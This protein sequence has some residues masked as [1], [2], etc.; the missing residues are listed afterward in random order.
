MKKKI[1]ITITNDNFVR[2]YIFSKAFLDIEKEFS[3][4]YLVDKDLK[5]KFLKKNTF[6]YSLKKNEKRIFEKYC[7]TQTF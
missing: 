7:L 3:C 1:L 6:F 5:I 4:F 2:N